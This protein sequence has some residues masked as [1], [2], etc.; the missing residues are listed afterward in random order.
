MLY[1]AFI[2][3]LRRSGGGYRLGPSRARGLGGNFRGAIDFFI[4]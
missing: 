4:W 3:R 1:L 2:C